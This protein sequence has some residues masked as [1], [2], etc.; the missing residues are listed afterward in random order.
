M[1][2]HSWKLI[3]ISSALAAAGVLACV[4]ALFDAFMPKGSL[5][6]FLAGIALLG[7][8]VTGVLIGYTWACDKCESYFNGRL[9][10]L[11]GPAKPQMSRH[12][13]LDKEKELW[14]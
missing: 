11:L 7:L 10:R 13:S 14:T 4:A 9:D 12:I 2:Y 8:L 5:T 6:A 3:T 1:C